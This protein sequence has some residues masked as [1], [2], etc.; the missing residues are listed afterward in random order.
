MDYHQDYDDYYEDYQLNPGNP[1]APAPMQPPPGNGHQVVPAAGPAHWM[2]LPEPA[3]APMT[4]PAGPSP[5]M[6]MDPGF[7]PAV[8]PVVPMTMDPSA[9]AVGA[10]PIQPAMG[11]AMSMDP[12]MVVATQPVAPAP[13][14]A[15][16]F[17][18]GVS[19]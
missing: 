10:I 7:A 14:V 17:K 12:L 19:F 8:Q 3:M 1:V 13:V 18:Q 6:M 9:F 15:T 5:M 4:Q 16:A 2:P 11:V